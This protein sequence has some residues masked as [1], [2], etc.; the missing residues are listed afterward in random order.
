V[1][2]RAKK[3]RRPIKGFYLFVTNKGTPYT[4]DGFKSIWQRVVDKAEIENIHFHDIRA[5]ALTDAKRLG[6]DAQVL[7][8]HEHSS[9][10]DRYIKDR[11]FDRVTTPLSIKKNTC[12]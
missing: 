4:Y 9:T 1:I 11:E 8:G 7:A 2:S 3:L 10:T 5:K 6:Y 12:K